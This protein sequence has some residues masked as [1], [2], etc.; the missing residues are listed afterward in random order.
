[1]FRRYANAYSQSKYIIFVIPVKVQ[2]FGNLETSFFLKNFNKKILRKKIYVTC[3]P[4]PSICVEF[5][6]Y[7]TN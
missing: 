6:S 7:K 1:M 5:Y 4:Y 3:S 2:S